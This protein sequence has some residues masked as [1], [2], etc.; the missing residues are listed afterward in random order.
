MTKLPRGLCPSDEMLCGNTAGN[1]NR[2]L[3]QELAEDARACAGRMFAHL[4]DIDC[5][6]ESHDRDSR[7]T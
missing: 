2:T 5:D 4:R 3:A 6:G 7:T 1:I